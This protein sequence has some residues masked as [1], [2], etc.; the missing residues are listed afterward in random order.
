L[1]NEA[2]MVAM[3]T[4]MLLAVLVMSL[5]IGG[6]FHLKPEKRLRG[7]TSPITQGS[8]RFMVFL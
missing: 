1:V 3:G 6:Y 7:I 8:Y 2:I 5:V 4:L